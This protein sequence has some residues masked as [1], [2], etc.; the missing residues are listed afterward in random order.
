MAVTIIEKQSNKIA[1]A[2]NVRDKKFLDVITEAAIGS[3]TG[4]LRLKVRGDEYCLYFEKGSLVYATDGKKPIEKMVFDIIKSSGFISRE[5]L[6]FCERQKSS[7]MK[8][9]L[10]MLID[11]GYISMMLYSKVISTAMRINIINA[12][13]ENEGDYSFEIR[14]RIDSVQGV[15]P[16]TITYLKSVDALIAENRNAAKFVADSFYST[17]DEKSKV[18]YLIPKSSFLHCA[19]A[20][21]TDFLKFFVAAVTDFVEK[22]WSFQSFF[23]KDRIL[24]SAAVYTFRILLVVSLAAF[25]YLAFMT[26]ALD[27]KSE[28]VSGRDFYFIQDKMVKSLQ[29]FQNVENVKK[30]DPLK[31]RGKDAKEKKLKKNKK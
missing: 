1:F 29:E 15:R 20:A 11:E 3:L 2:G 9:V 13:L 27:L 28:V 19:I 4:F 22:K 5:K 7:M 18:V 10:E 23:K 16:V 30:P 12:M 24:N 17:I 6:I 8:T 31:F 26:T 21:E 25:I 14:P